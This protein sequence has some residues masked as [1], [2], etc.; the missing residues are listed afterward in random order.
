MAQGLET[1]AGLGRTVFRNNRIDEMS[2]KTRAN[3]SAFL[4][5]LPANEAMHVPSPNACKPFEKSW[6]LEFVLKTRANSSASQYVASSQRSS[7]QAIS[8]DFP[9]VHPVVASISLLPNG[10]LPKLYFPQFPVRPPSRH[11]HLAPSQQSSPQAISHSCP[12][13]HPVIAFVSL[14]PNG[15]LPKLFPTVSPPSTLSSLPSC[16]LPTEVSPSY[17][18]RFPLRPPCRQSKLN[19]NPSI[20]DPF[21]KKPSHK[22]ELSQATERSLNHH[23]KDHSSHAEKHAAGSAGSETRTGES[24]AELAQLLPSIWAGV[25]DKAWYAGQRAGQRTRPRHREMYHPSHSGSPSLPKQK[26]EWRLQQDGAEHKKPLHRMHWHNCRPA[27]ST[28]PQL[29][30]QRSCPVSWKSAAGRPFSRLLASFFSCLALISWSFAT[31]SSCLDLGKFMKLSNFSMAATEPFSR[32][33]P[34][35]CT[36]KPLRCPGNLGSRPRTSTKAAIATS[37]RSCPGN[38]TSIDPAVACTFPRSFQ[39]S[40]RPWRSTG[41]HDVIM[42]CLTQDQKIPGSSAANTCGSKEEDLPVRAVNASS[43]LC[44]PIISSSVMSLSRSWK[45]MQRFSKIPGQRTS[46]RSSFSIWPSW[47]TARW[48]TK[49]PFFTAS[50]L[51]RIAV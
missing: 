42:A 1:L 31:I 4:V 41:D 46:K 26:P 25:A 32:S 6:A 7:P 50:I 19:E 35:I 8:H 27:C 44:R 47:P 23:P 39:P 38:S 5:S 13:I 29:Q 36:S 17:F 33:L 10:A 30:Q 49:D 34:M 2:W 14:L 48:S 43:Q 18:P 20:G 9:S 37:S 45:T 15:A 16:S 12:S 40:S 21:G 51:L 28:L 3:S 24:D 11:F 22:W